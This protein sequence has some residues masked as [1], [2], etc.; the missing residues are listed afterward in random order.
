[1]KQPVA[2]LVGGPSAEHDVS[3][4]SGRSIA[5][6]LAERGYPVEGWLIGLDGSWWRLPAPAMD[7]A[8]PAIAYDNPARLGAH[9]PNRAAAALAMLAAQ[10]PR[11]TVF[12]AL[13]GPF[14]EDGTVQALCESEGLAYTGSGPAASA[15][16]MDKA[17]F[18]RLVEGQGIPVVRWQ[19]ATSGE[20]AADR[21]AA[22]G[23]LR[24]FSRALPDARLIVKPACL[25]SSIGMTVV[26]HPDDGPELE[27]ALA[28]AFRFDDRALVEQYLDHARE[29]EVSVVGNG[30]HD[31]EV[32]GPGE[33]FP[34][35]AYCRE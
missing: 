35:H 1:M 8:I 3:L 17:L 4:V 13:H 30:A 28:E 33:V 12:I 23:A 5:A 29:L 6:A 27:G 15:L 31:V 24:A 20:F 7:R 9:G 16:G 10:D 14:G 22:L 18:K 26:E 25:G 11:P 34:G 19:E 21:R 2:V 32:F